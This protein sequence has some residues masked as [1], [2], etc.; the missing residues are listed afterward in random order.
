MSIE[1]PQVLT[2]SENYNLGRYGEVL[3]SNGRLFNPSNE[4]LPGDDA[5]ARQAQNNLN[6][7][8]MDDGLSIQNPESIIFPAPGLSADNTLRSSDSVM[9]IHGVMHFAFNTYRIIPTITP[10]FTATNPR[11]HAPQFD[12]PGRLKAASFNVLNFFNGDGLGGGFPT[13]RGADTD[14]ELKRQRDK[15]VN[16]VIA[17]D[18]D[19]IGLIEIENDGYAEHS[20][21]AELVNA[22]ND[23]LIVPEDHYAYVTATNDIIGDDEIAV[24]IIYRKHIVSPSGAAAI[25]T[26]ANSIED[27]D[28]PGQPLFLDSKNRP[29]LA[30]TF[31]EIQSNAKLTVVVNH[32]KSKGSPCDDIGDPDLQDGQGNCNKTRNNAARALIAWLNSGTNITHNENILILGD[33]NAYAKEDPITTLSRSHY[34]NLAAHFDKPQN[35]YSYTFKGQAGTL[36]YAFANPNLLKQV[37]DTTIWHINSD[38]PRALD[39]NEEF[40]SDN[41]LASLYSPSP[42]R[43]SDHDP[44]IVSM[45]LTPP[46]QNPIAQ[47]KYFRLFRWVVFISKSTDHDGHI[48]NHHWDF[49]D[50][51]QS[52]GKFTIHRYQKSGHYK[53]THTVHDN[54]NASDSLQ[55]IIHIR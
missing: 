7:L 23:A 33:L 1:L 11:P 48:N 29:A 30:Q 52:S 36:D 9:G 49:G 2:I 43:S 14:N 25:L 26:S 38:E 27:P 20:A 13:A 16:A 35:R 6:Q 31:T 53:V 54:Q 19:I 34:T 4:V 37:N 10:V 18:A 8:L 41:Q 3:L 45:T 51:R 12:N 44:V 50:G 17:V 40:K 15:I 28:N 24:G 55:T 5:I 22:I 46:N 47:F 21:I 39:Y 32:F 42:Y